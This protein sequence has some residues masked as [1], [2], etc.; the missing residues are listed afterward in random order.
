MYNDSRDTCATKMTACSGVPAATDFRPRVIVVGGSQNALS[1]VRNLTRNGIE[2]FVINSP[3]EAVRFSRFG[4][5]IR[6]DKNDTA[7]AWEEFLLGPHSEYLRG[8]VLLPCSDEAISI[9][10]ENYNALAKKFRL[11][12]TDPLVRAELLDKFATYRRAK[13]VGIPAVSC[14]AIHSKEDFEQAI[15]ELCFP[16]IA[17]PLY[18]PD[19]NVLKC[20][21]AILFS[22]LASLKLHVERAIREEVGVVLMDYI[23]GGDDRL[24]SYFTYLDENGDPL[25]HFTKR[26]KRRFPLESGDGTYH[27]TAWIPEAA[28][29]GLRFFRHLNFRG[30]GNVEF[31]WDERDGKLKIIEANARFTASDCLIAKSGVNLALI[32]YNRIVG[33][34]Q[35]AVM[36]FVESLALCRPL[37]DS[38]AAWQ[39]HRKGELRLVDWLADLRRANMVP[40][41]EWR[42]PIPAVAALSRRLCKAGSRVLPWSRTA[43]ARPFLGVEK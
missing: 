38:F 10:V 13:D 42:D 23:P 33:I 29:L 27:V 19:R 39:L 21:K 22:D 1:V 5:Y 7:A 25:V 18:A 6:L 9:V 11:E 16:L 35:P 14:W 40:F 17:K 24:C 28:E 37:E 8:S 3:Y 12:E 43:D 36:Q 32:T 4:H 30:L 31:K 34:M 26:V 41:F 15:P 2:V 20:A